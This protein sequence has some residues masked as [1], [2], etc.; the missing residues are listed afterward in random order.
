MGKGQVVSAAGALG[1]KAERCCSQVSK[2]LEAASR[3]FLNTLIK[4]TC[5]LGVRSV[6]SGWAG[7][8]AWCRDECCSPALPR[9][10][11]AAGVW[12]MVRFSVPGAWRSP[13]TQVL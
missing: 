10:L 9:L 6:R 1:V 8:G 11:R 3:S 7:G 4:Q 13:C 12:S 2:L 5:C